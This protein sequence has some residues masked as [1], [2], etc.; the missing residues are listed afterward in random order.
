MAGKTTVAVVH[1]KVIPGSPGNYGEESLRV[2][3]GM[4]K[5]AVDSVGG[6]KSVIKRWGQGSGP[7]QCLLGGET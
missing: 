2:V 4:L 7:G 1:R 3:Y 6:M 5:K